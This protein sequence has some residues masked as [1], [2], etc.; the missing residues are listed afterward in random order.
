[1]NVKPK[2][3]FFDVMSTLV[4]DPFFIEVP[5]HFNMSL[6]ELIKNKDRNAWPA[7]ERDDITETQFFESFF[8]DGRQVDGAAMKACMHDN[9]RFLD[10]IEPLLQELLENGVLMYSLSNYPNWYT[11]I[12]DKLK[13][14]RYMDWRFV[15]CLTKVRKPEPR[16][17]LGPAEALGVSPQQCLFI[18][19]RDDNCIGAKAVGM[20]AIQY[21]STPQLRHELR[22][23]G[24][25]K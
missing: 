12:E 14:T 13:L 21:H 3:V 22:Q 24:L 10:G 4:Y 23:Y 11:L 19:D 2:V 20:M 7:F 18:D 15:S 17:Y 9:Y 16:A 8:G 6:Q 5:A 25:V 1:M